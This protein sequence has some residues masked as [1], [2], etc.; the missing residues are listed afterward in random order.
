MVIRSPLDSP[1]MTSAL[2]PPPANRPKFWRFYRDRDLSPVEVGEVFGRSAEWVRLIC[3]PFDDARRRVP[4]KSD[5]LRIREWSGG[6]VGPPDWYPEPVTPSA[7]ADREAVE[8]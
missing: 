6:E 2:A 4:D 7:P 1:A 5:V 8:S 3:L